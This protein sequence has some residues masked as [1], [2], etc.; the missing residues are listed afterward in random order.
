MDELL[1][2]IL[3]TKVLRRQHDIYP[4]ITAYQGLPS[5]NHRKAGVMYV[6][7]I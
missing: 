7:Q 3:V 5:W 6:R 1:D 2:L 4:G